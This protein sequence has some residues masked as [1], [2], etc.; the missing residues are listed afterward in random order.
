MARLSLTILAT[1]LM[2]GC[3]G[4]P[5]SLEPTSPDQAEPGQNQMGALRC[6]G[7]W[8]YASSGQDPWVE[9]A[10]SQL[11]LEALRFGD[12]DDDG[13]TDVFATWGGQ[14]RVSYQAR[15]SWQTLN[16]MNA[17][18]DTLAFGDF[19]G[20]ARTDVFRSANG[21]WTVSD[22][23][24][25][26]WQKLASSGYT[27]DRLGFADVVGDG[28]LDVIRTS[29]TRWQVAENG[30]WSWERLAD[31]GYTLDQMAFDHFIGDGKHEVFISN[32]GQWQVWDPN[33]G[34]GWTNLAFSNTPFEELGFADINGDGVTDVL[35]HWG[36]T[37]RV[38][39]GGKGAWVELLDTPHPISALRFGQFDSEP[40]DDVFAIER[41]DPEI[42]V[43]NTGAADQAAGL[44]A[45][46]DQWE[47]E[48][49]VRWA[50]AEVTTHSCVAVF[51]GF[52][53]QAAAR[54][55]P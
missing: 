24:S 28:R 5:G 49:G 3:A 16:T 12:F 43:T 11:P 45:V 15:Q 47:A 51:D 8:V 55:C 50:D 39:Y 13:V 10:S 19:F 22:G 53:C 7:Q 37:L 31:S 46:Q 1:A 44:Q 14:W 20:D 9:L 38:A 34:A 33:A 26:S 4:Q 41:P 32:S 42:H 52:V 27:V 35:A 30:D 36:G 40:G 17:A 25:G 54:Y 2:A 48:T 29:G 23:G 6:S 21:E 18:L